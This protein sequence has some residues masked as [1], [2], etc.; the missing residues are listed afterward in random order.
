MGRAK[1]EPQPD[2]VL[3]ALGE[4]TAQLED[5]LSS[6]LAEL[7]KVID[8]SVSF[9]GARIAALIGE[10]RSNADEA[11]A[12][13]RKQHIG[14]I[15]VLRQD[16]S[17]KLDDF[18]GSVLSIRPEVGSLRSDLAAH[19]LSTSEMRKEHEVAL[20]S[21]REAFQTDLAKLSN[22]SGAQVVDATVKLREVVEAQKTEVFR[23][24]AA[25]ETSS[26]KLEERYE[27]L[28]KSLDTVTGDLGKARSMTQA[29]LM[30]LAS[31]FEAEQGKLRADIL[32]EVRTSVSQDLK[33][34]VTH[35]LVDVR[36]KL[37]GQILAL[38]DVVE[39]HG[40]SV[41]KTSWM[42]DN[43]YTRSVTWRISNFKKKTF[44]LV[45][46]EEEVSLVSPGFSVCALPEM[47]MELQVTPPSTPVVP[48]PGAVAAPMPGSCSL[49]VWAPPGLK[50][51][52]RVSGGEGS[53]AVSRR[54]EHTFQAGGQED[55]RGRTCFQA[56][57]I[58]ELNKCF[59]RNTDTA[60]FGFELLEFRV[61]GARGSAP[62]RYVQSLR[63]TSTGFSTTGVLFG[64][65]GR[66]M[67]STMY[68]E[69]PG[70]E[71]LEAAGGDEAMSP[72][73]RPGSGS[74][75]GSA[76]LGLPKLA[77]EDDEDEELEDIS[78]GETVG[79]GSISAARFA[80]SDQALQEK[81][82]KEQQA[83]R[84]RAVR[85]IEWRLEGC[86]KLLEN[87]SVGQAVDSPLFSA[88]GLQGLQLHFYP[89]GNDTNGA[90]SGASQ[91]CG[92]FVSGP[93][94]ASI[95]GV[96]WVGSFSKSFEHR[97][98]RK[99]DAGGRSK[100]C[101]L[102][103]TLDC[104]DAVV[105]A[106]D[107]TEVESDVPDLS[108]TLCL[109]EARTGPNAGAGGNSKPTSQGGG[110]EDGGSKSHGRV[111][112]PAMVAGTKGLLRMRREDAMKSEEVM[113]CVSLPSL[114]NRNHNVPLV[115]TG[116]RSH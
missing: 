6:E 59:T 71:C 54:Y 93:A 103:K 32:E 94:R 15:S 22:E 78:I 105:L 87:C 91:W 70:A 48:L 108:T 67:D 116:Q 24:Q 39:A 107:L 110:R 90:G 64:A 2:P 113:R 52:F 56:Q 27:D 35:G 11:V 75:R 82:Q 66:Q 53:G 44:A 85:R 84:N 45:K 18:S 102:D 88:A 98:Q 17:Q 49:R 50:A 43:M 46:A 34:T 111:N 100:F 99:G 73:Q 96:L 19:V 92:L 60:S 61:P 41:Q 106:L 47:T 33:E 9:E 58:C 62:Q 26:S 4:R 3:V 42:V 101:D 1:A 114:N 80:T 109:R 31:A 69:A 72:S 89:K 51:V 97:F 28:Q 115:R 14:E 29:A 77:M 8:S 74:P 25:L 79:I 86:A 10:V 76:L 12:A 37:D 7:R 81:L 30:D 63:G 65:D 57:N 13:V 83:M 16:L 20:E 23:M 38:E 55:S 112:H 95:R 68:S 36:E 5:R 104:E 40:A 21:V